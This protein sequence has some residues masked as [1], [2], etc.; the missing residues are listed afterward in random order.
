MQQ[1]KIFLR[2]IN[3]TDEKEIWQ[4]VSSPLVTRYLTW[5]YYTDIDT[6]TKYFFVAKH[7]TSFPDEVLAIVSD[8]GSVIG[9]VHFILRKDTAIQFGFG[10]LPELWH[11]G[12]GMEVVRVSLAY[13]KKNKSW[14]VYPIW[15]DVH[16]ENSAAVTILKKNKFELVQRAVEL[17]RDR[18]ILNLAK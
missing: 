16:Q 1:Q 14:A 9:T 18:Y 15:A 17:Q 10:I 6:F 3:D 12:I 5:D 13:L 7:K 4:Y 2:H 11:R 8:T